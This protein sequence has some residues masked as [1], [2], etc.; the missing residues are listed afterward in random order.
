MNLSLMADDYFHQLPFKKIYFKKLYYCI[1][2][3]EAA[4]LHAIFYKE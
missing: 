3:F 1:M 2:D 4:D